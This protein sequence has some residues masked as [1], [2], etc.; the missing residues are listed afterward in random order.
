MDATKLAHSLELI[1]GRA[2]R[3]GLTVHHYPEAQLAVIKVPAV[4]PPAATDTPPPE[5]PASEPPP[6]E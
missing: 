5:L 3:E 1:V 4:K 2:K 6:A